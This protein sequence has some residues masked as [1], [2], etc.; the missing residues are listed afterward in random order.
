MSVSDRKSS[1]SAASEPA[2]NGKASRKLTADDAAKINALA[3]RMSASLGEITALLLQSRQHR[4]MFLSELELM[5]T[6]AL[7]TGQFAIAEG[8]HKESGLS[9]PR[10][11]IIWA[12]VSKEVDARL[13]AQVGGPIRLKPSEW[14]SGTNAWLVEAVG[15]PRAIKLLIDQAITGPLKSRGLKVVTRGPS[16]KPAVQHV[17]APA[18]SATPASGNA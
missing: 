12:S 1:G 2:P 9:T 7:S 17:K 11:A 3:K 18:S 15:E 8:R 6:P 13:A 14:A 16:G 10:A 5:V 4:H